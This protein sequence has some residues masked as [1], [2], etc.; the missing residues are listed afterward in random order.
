MICAVPATDYVWLKLIIVLYTSELDAAH[1][2]FALEATAETK[3]EDQPV[4]MPSK[5]KLE[6][7]V[8]ESLRGGGA[9]ERT[10]RGIKV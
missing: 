7:Q 9:G 5:P 10:G 3:N 2:S 1:S 8:E 4:I 6:Q